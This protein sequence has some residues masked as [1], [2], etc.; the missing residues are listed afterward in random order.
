[1]SKLVAN[2]G[3]VGVDFGY[4]VTATSDMIV[5]GARRDDKG[6]E[7]GSVYVFEKNNNGQY[8]QVANKLVSTA[9]ADDR[10]GWRVA[11]TDDVVVVGAYLDDDKGSASGS[12]C[13]FE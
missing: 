7:S 8:A 2:N 10:F 9:G 6:R 5:V 12:V 1:V 13:V 4:A 11:A 3:A